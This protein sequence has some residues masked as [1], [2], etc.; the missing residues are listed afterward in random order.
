MTPDPAPVASS[1]SLVRLRVPADSRYARVVRVAVGAFAIQIGLRPEVVEDLRLAVDEA[2]ILLL[3]TLGA[4]ED[5]THVGLVVVL[6]QD[7]TS[8]AL[9]FAV[10]TD[11]EPEGVAAGADALARFHELIPAEVT[12]DGVDLAGGRVALHLTSPVSGDESQAS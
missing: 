9:A 7:P 3:A 2:L 12:V 11:P 10:G 1:V 5:T 8:G 4:D 6:D